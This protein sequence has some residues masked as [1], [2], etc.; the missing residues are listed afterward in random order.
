MVADIAKR[1]AANPTKNDDSMKLWAELHQAVS[2]LP[3]EER[4]PQEQMQLVCAALDRLVRRERAEREMPYSPSG[5]VELAWQPIGP[6]APA[7]V[8]LPPAGIS[9]AGYILGWDPA[10]QGFIHMR[11]SDYHKF[12]AAWLYKDD[13]WSKVTDA[14]VHLDTSEEWRGFHDPSRGGVVGWNFNRD[15]P[16][17]VLL[18]AQGLVLLRCKEQKSVGDPQPDTRWLEGEVPIIESSPWDALSGVFGYDRKRQVTVLLS[19][20]AVWELDAQNTWHKRFD[21]PEGLLPSEVSGN[22]SFGDAGAGAAWDEPRQ[23][24]VFWLG[25]DDADTL[26]F[27]VSDGTSLAELGVEGLPEELLVKYGSPPIRHTVLEHPTHGVVVLGSRGCFAHD[28]AAWRPVQ[29]AENAPPPNSATAVATRP[30]TGEILIGPGKYVGCTPEEQHIFWRLRGGRWE[31]Q[32]QLRA[33]SPLKGLGDNTTTLVEIGGEILAIGCTGLETLRWTDGQGFVLQVS[34]Q[35]GEAV[36]AG[37]RR[38]EVAAMPDGSLRAVVYDGSV[39]RYDGGAWRRESGPS[40]LFKARTGFLV[41]GMPDGTLLVWGGNSGQAPCNEALLHTD[42]TWRKAKGQSPRPRDWR[43]TYDSSGFSVDFSLLWDTHLETVV[44]FGY[45]EIALWDRVEE[46]W[47]VVGVKH[48]QVALAPDDSERVI[49]AVGRD[50]VVVNWRSAI[51]SRFDLRGFHLV[52][53]LPAW[54][55]PIEERAAE[56]L[57]HTNHLRFP[58]DQT[59]GRAEA[60]CAETFSPDDPHSNWRLDLS[61]AIAALAGLPARVRADELVPPFPPMWRYHRIEGD[62]ADYWS[63]RYQDGAVV[64]ERG[65]LSALFE[66][67]AGVTEKLPIPRDKAAAESK[68]LSPSEGFV[69]AAKLELEFLE[70]VGCIAAWPLQRKKVKKGEAM[71]DSRIG[72]TPAIDEARWPKDASGAPMAFLFQ[73]RVPSGLPAEA[74][75]VAVFCVADGTATEEAENNVVLLLSEKELTGPGIVPP[76]GL[77]KTSGVLALIPGKKKSMVDKARITRWLEADPLIAERYE[78]IERANQVPFD[79]LG[80]LPSWIQGSEGDEGFVAELDFDVGEVPK[81]WDG[82]GLS[83]GIYVFLSGSDASASWQYT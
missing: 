19:A 43:H 35:D 49:F 48:S 78:A 47:Q 53:R 40:P 62:D 8:T 24:L 44:R 31:Q 72:G 37:G 39:L 79:R 63:C 11:Q 55:E 34:K 36:L 59:L 57:K 51:V 4:P 25:D 81:G 32:G 21:V 17:G 28:G 61:P 30:D 58:F 27:F 42:G 77:P 83:G 54:P 52:A 65:R 75:G 80:G 10:R 26:R 41:A 68:R 13:V 76:K 45:E 67:K 7:A 2:T 33:D 66:G 18:G 69:G 12:G 15:R 20:S 74:A 82:L 5:A 23:R 29:L 14:V 1:A 64:V 50:I 70:K 71:P 3:E 9:L 6:P 22:T 46:A 16:F 60:K 73:L 56:M 38:A